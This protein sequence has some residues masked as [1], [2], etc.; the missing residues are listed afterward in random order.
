M[1]GRAAD[2]LEV[3]ALEFVGPAL[4]VP[5]IWIVA[6]RVIGFRAW[7]VGTLRYPDCAIP[8]A[9]CRLGTVD[10]R[11]CLK[12]RNPTPACDSFAANSAPETPDPTMI[13][14]ASMSAMTTL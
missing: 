3:S 12:D 9:L 13:T 7:R 14:S 11:T 2:D 5:I 1:P 8:E 10:P 6:D 4:A